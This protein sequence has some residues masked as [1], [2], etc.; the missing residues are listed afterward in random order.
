MA[1]IEVR[2]NVSYREI[3]VMRGD[4]EIAGAKSPESQRGVM[5]A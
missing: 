2:H 4:S 3:N 1:L 5:A